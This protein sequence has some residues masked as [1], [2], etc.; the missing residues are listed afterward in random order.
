MSKSTLSITIPAHFTEGNTY[1]G[2]RT[3]EVPCRLPDSFTFRFKQGENISTGVAYLAGLPKDS[4]VAD[5]ELVDGTGSE[6]GIPEIDSAAESIL[7]TVK[8]MLGIT[9]LVSPGSP[10]PA[11]ALAY[12]AEVKA[13]DAQVRAYDAL[14]AIIT[15]GSSGLVGSHPAD[16][17]SGPESS[18]AARMLAKYVE[19]VVQNAAAQ[20]AP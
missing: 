2:K 14:P 11:I 19:H 15:A 3:I 17:M 10:L 1:I 20:V 12:E 6:D 7:A 4:L 18:P 5:V 16:T 9:G 13:F 8:A